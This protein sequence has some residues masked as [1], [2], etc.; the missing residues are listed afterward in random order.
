MPCTTVLVGKK[1]SYDGSTLVARND[2]SPSGKFH[3]KKML[4]LASSD[5]EKIYRSVISHV[6]IPLPKH[7]FAYTSMPNVDPKEGVWAAAGVNCKNVSMSATETITTNPRVL[8]GDPFVE[9]QEGKNGEPMH[10]GGIGEEDLVSIVLP[11]ISTAREGVLRLG[12]LLEEYGTYEPNG[13]AFSD[14]NNI[15]WLETIGGHHWIARRVKDEEVV[16]MPNQFGLDT[17][18]FADAKGEGKENL[19]S[20]DLEEFIINN[21]L[22]LSLD[23]SINPRLCFGSHD[24]SDHVYNTPRAWFAYRYL[25]P[26]KHY[27]DGPKADVTPLDDDIPWSLIPEKKVTI[28]DVKYILSSHYQGTEYDP[29]G[30]LN[31]PNKGIFRPIGISRTSFMSIAQLRNNVEE[32]LVPIQWVCYGSN[33]FNA[34]IPLYPAAEEIPPYLKDTT[35][36]VSTDSF[37]WASRLL[38][39]IGDAH[40]GTCSIHIERYQN[41][42]AAASHAI[43]SET[44]KLFLKTSNKKQTLIEAN[45]KIA[46]MARS[47][48]D[49]ALNS[50]LYEASCHMKNGFARSDN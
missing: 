38:G 41:A 42:V 33:A 30:K 37:Y 15:W 12:A 31:T 28:E 35:L 9:Y 11:Y 13:I 10:R 5:E 8:G 49:K 3:V 50:L 43:V 4:F 29:Y 18:D 16:V 27:Y 17:F 24:D 2:D 39:V 7:S 22:N 26:H 21:S 25:C 20:K 46:S 14:Q 40:F 45:N 47:E 32:T 44:D 23:G 1:A 36:N 19:C 48:T 6:E 34:L